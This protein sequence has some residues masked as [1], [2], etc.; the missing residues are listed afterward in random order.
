[1]ESVKPDEKRH[2]VRV[3]LRAR[4]EFT[5][6]DA[7]EYETIRDEKGEMPHQFIG[8]PTKPVA[9]AEEENYPPGGAVD[10]NLIHFLIHLEEKMDRVLKLLSKDQK[11]DEGLFTGQGL[12]ISGGGMKILCDKA[13]KP[14]Q[15]LKISSKNF[16]YPVVSL[17]VFGEVARVT[18]LQDDGEQRYEVGVKF[19][20][21]NEECRERII[22]YIFQMQREAIR[23]SK[24][25]GE[26]TVDS[27]Q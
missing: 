23:S 11:C 6:M 2:R 9:P 10:P 12:D 13:V 18:P 26:R 19:L 22:A 25:K 14:G 7:H 8:Q 17:E 4:V 1:M 27:G 15:I 5:V 16:R 21:L 3:P 20:D 24:L